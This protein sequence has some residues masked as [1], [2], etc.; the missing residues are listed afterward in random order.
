[1]ACM[2]VLHNKLNILFMVAH[3]Q[4]TSGLSM[5]HDIMVSPQ[6]KTEDDNQ[7]ADI[8]LIGRQLTNPTKDEENIFLD[9]SNVIGGHVDATSDCDDDFLSEQLGDNDVSNHTGDDDHVPE[10]KPE[11]ETPVE[12]AN[13]T[14]LKSTEIVLATHS[15]I[16]AEGNAVAGI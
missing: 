11:D 13:I 2:L 14:G 4:D 16:K 15:P 9:D 12:E 3:V 8:A 7:I 5:S 1:M 6:S 10:Q